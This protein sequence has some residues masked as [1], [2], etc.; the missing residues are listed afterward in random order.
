MV[1]VLELDP[2]QCQNEYGVSPCT[3]GR[4]TTGTAQAG[5]STTITLAVAA[6]AVDDAYNTQTV[7][8]TGGTGSGQERRITDYVGAT[9]VATVESA[10]GVNPDATSTYSVINR[11]GACY[12]T[13][14]TC[15]DIP[16][17]N[18]GS[19][20]IKFC[21][22][23]APIP[24]GQTYRP[25]IEQIKS[26]PTEIKPEDGLAV[27]STS[28]VKL[29]DEIC[30]DIGQDPY[31]ADRATVAEGTYWTRFLARNYNYFGRAARV[32]RAYLTGDWDD[33]EFTT[34][35]YIIDS[36]KGPTGKGDIAIT[37]KD[38]IKLLDRIKIPTPT[39]GKLAVALLT[40]D[41]QMTLGTGE[42]DQYPASGYVRVGDQII[43]YTS[44]VADVLAWPDSTYRSKF[45][46]TAVNLAVGEGVQ[47][48]K[49]WIDQPLTT[50]LQDIHNDSGIVD[51]NLDLVGWAVEE[52]N[53]L[54]PR[55]NITTCIPDP[56]DASVLAKELCK[57]SNS[58]EWWSPTEQTVRYKV[59]GPRN[60]SEVSDSTLTDEAHFI[61]D[62][63][64]V[65][66]LDNLRITFAVVNYNLDSA[67]A[68]K[69]EIKNYRRGDINVDT[70]A[71]GPNEYNDQRI[72]AVNSRWFTADNA[73]AMMSLVSR[74]IAYY[75][76]P[77]K[78]IEF[79]V[80]P[81][82]V[83]IREG[84]YRDLLTKQIVDVTGAPD[85]KRVLITK[86]QDDGNGRIKLTARTTTFDRRY[87]FIAPAGRPDY[88]LSTE[89]E[90]AY[91]Y[92]CNSS[93]LMSNGDQGYLVI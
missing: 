24:V 10:W 86:R 17:Y 28:S 48:C 69:E 66:S 12:R 41:L 71:E 33:L 92:I 6:S 67:V 2:D 54:G 78:Q 15:Q 39:S 65:T 74:K 90:Q 44:N 59:I 55:Y 23:G 88:L 82:D 29:I 73:Q 7:H 20:T 34:E 14:G 62:S 63:V 56:E 61:E 25:Y 3:A 58:V 47:L 87:A 75:R 76:D 26:A 31:V 27:R 9:K 84:D 57:E 8:I 85:Q 38:P 11:P 81:K 13:F 53:W 51:A 52:A 93:G 1:E 4:T 35:L 49:V 19:Q 91:A 43:Q 46:T 64:T 37:L 70:D 21:S 40:S 45:N 72:D 60:P 5:A 68:D 89:T 77:P 50:V 80:D 42:G 16:N 32:K 83:D 30:S 22:R 18:K 79:S 36:I